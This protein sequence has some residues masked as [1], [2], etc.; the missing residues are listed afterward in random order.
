M[1]IFLK[2]TI[3]ISALK[4]ESEKTKFDCL[5]VSVHFGNHKDTNVRLKEMIWQHA[6]VRLTVNKLLQ[7]FSPNE[8]ECSLKKF[9][10]HFPV[11]NTTFLLD[12]FDL[13]SDCLSR[14]K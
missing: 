9:I 3:S 1:A 5:A 13:A 8:S 14:L 10:L 4:N 6:K 2:V 11:E 12:D 7:G